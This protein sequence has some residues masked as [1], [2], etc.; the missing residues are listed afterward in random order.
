MLSS[1][2]AFKYLRDKKQ[3]FEA[4][5]SALATKPILKRPDFDAA[6]IGASPFLLDTYTLDHA[7]G[8][9][10]SQLDCVDNERLIYFHSRQFSRT[11]ANYTMTEWEGLAI[12]LSALR[13]RPYVLG[14]KIVIQTDH[15]A[16]AF[17]FRNES[18]NR[19]IVR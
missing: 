16:L 11:E 3:S 4:L 2:M 15:N 18:L 5:M 10:L 6:R 12:V 1:K 19:R 9:V 14:T 17:M 13:F 8:G 7:L